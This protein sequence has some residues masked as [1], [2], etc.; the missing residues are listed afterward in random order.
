MIRRAVSARSAVVTIETGF[1]ALRSS[2]EYDPACLN[3]NNAARRRHNEI[4]NDFFF[5][6]RLDDRGDTQ[7]RRRPPKPRL[8]ERVC[9]AEAIRIS[10]D[11][12]I[13]VRPAEAAGEVL[14]ALGDAGAESARLFGYDFSNYDALYAD[15]ADAAVSNARAKAEA[16]SSGAGGTLGEIVEMSVSA[17]DRI[18]RFGPQPTV[19]RPPRPSSGNGVNALQSYRDRAGQDP[20]EGRLNRYAAPAPVMAMEAADEIVVTATKR[21][22]TRSPAPVTV[23]ALTAEAGVTANAGPTTIGGSS[24]SGSSLGSNALTMSLMSGPQ[25]IE[26]AA[27]LA[28]AYPTPLDGIVIQEPDND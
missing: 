14:R 11:M 21:Q 18:G 4:R 6:K 13:R 7:T 3:A 26:V 8:L 16:V 23:S 10:T 28:F 15:A 2:P 24:G 22:A 17:P 19:I 12:V 20:V 25:T 5:N 27:R 9:Q 1:T